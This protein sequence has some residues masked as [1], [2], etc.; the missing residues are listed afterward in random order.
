MGFIVIT[1][2]TWNLSNY[3]LLD[4]KSCFHTQQSVY[5]YLQ[6]I[7]SIS[8]GLQDSGKATRFSIEARFWS[9]TS[10]SLAPK[11]PNDNEIK[12]SLL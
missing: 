8:Q 10:Y 1:I 7:L 11:E 4:D 5:L 3:V 6:N 2:E 12:L 9:A